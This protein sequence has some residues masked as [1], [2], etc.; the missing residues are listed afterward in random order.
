MV[1]READ[2]RAYCGDLGWWRQDWDTA[3]TGLHRRTWLFSVLTAPH[4]P[5]F[6][7]LAADIDLAT[8]AL[9]PKHYRSLEAAVGSRA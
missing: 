3:E 9:T 4:A 7:D 8:S 2:L 1:R 5:V 6:L